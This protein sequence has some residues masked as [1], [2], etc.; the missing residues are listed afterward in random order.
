MLDEEL[1][2]ALKDELPEVK[3]IFISAVTGYGIPELKDMI[4][5][6]L[7]DEA[8]RVMTMTHH[9]PD[10]VILP[11]A[12]EEDQEDIEDDEEEDDDDFDYANLDPEAYR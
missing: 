7:N 12:Q 3:F 10:N 9:L 11:S 6:E 4:W 8:N 1:M 5:E 2:D